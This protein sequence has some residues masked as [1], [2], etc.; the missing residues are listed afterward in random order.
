MATD[1]RD[2]FDH[3]ATR[4]TTTAGDQGGGFS[5]A[6]G[7]GTSL[8]AKPMSAG[9]LDPSADT[10]S[11]SG[12]EIRRDARSDA[13]SD[14]HTDTDTDTSKLPLGETDIEDRLRAAQ[15]TQHRDAGEPDAAFGR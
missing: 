13:R 4:R 10:R 15:R 12:A 7:G 14:T 5:S 1:A 11:D 9:D 8:G 2:E 6:T 3:T